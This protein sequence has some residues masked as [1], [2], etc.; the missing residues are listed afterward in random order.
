[1]PIDS[2][3]D[4]PSSRRVRASAPL[5]AELRRTV[6]RVH[7][8]AGPGPGDSADE[9]AS[10]SRR[11]A[12]LSLISQALRSTDL[13][14]ELADGSMACLLIG[15][16]RRERLSLLSWTLLD[17][18]ARLTSQAA[19]PPGPEAPEAPEGP[20]AGRTGDRAAADICIGICTGP[21]AG[22]GYATMAHHARTAMY[23]ARRQ[24]SG[25]AFFD[26]VGA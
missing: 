25:F 13:V 12:A 8:G 6:I 3:L 14:C 17:T 24:Q 1:M 2:A 22:Q 19:S 7:T 26:D 4:T 9:R 23:R 20:A 10:S 16:L 11:D 21:A 18:L 15:P 5:G